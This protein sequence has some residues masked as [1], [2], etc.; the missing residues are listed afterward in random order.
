MSR[1]LLC[2]AGARLCALPIEHVVETMRPLPIEAMP[3]APPFVCGLSMVRGV[4]LA[5]VDVGTLLGMSDLPAPSRFVSVRAGRRQVVLAVGEVLGVSDLPAASL[6]D[7]PPLLGEAGAGVA[8]AIGALESALLVV[9]QAS[10][11][12]PEEVWASIERRPPS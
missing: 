11:I 7:L 6:H 9:L 2:R 4:P 1:L 3:G 10:H 5:V 8:S 12:V